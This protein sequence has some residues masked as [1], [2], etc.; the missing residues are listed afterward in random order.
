[1]K[2]VAS[3][4]LLVLLLSGVQDPALDTHGPQ[5]APTLGG[6]TLDL[7]A[8]RQGRRPGEERAEKRFV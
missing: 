1:M 7:A 5:A 8:Q 3:T 6:P 2:L 4:A